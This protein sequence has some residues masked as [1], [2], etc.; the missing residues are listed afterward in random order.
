MMIHSLKDMLKKRYF[1][2]LKA[3]NVPERVMREAKRRA[4]EDEQREDCDRR[5]RGK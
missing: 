4:E 5:I 2:R 3:M 1:D